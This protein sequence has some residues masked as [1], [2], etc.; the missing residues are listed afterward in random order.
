MV[1]GD[2]LQCKGM[3]M[4]KFLCRLILLAPLSLLSAC[5]LP[6]QYSPVYHLD[7][8]EARVLDADTREPVVG[9]NV[10]AVYETD[11]GGLGGTFPGKILEVIE[12]VTDA[13]GRFS[14]PAIT[15]FETAVSGGFS[16]HYPADPGFMIFKPDYERGGGTRRT[17][18][19]YVVAENVP[20]DVLLL[21]RISYSTLYLVSDRKP[22][23]SKNSHP[24]FFA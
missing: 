16:K 24:R 1:C 17:I 3:T 4:R 14:F 15:L 19:G 13:Q 8:V 6:P 2:S 22:P 5:V 18:G 10:I 11:R 23:F 12:T 9:A 7:K 20:R 21:K